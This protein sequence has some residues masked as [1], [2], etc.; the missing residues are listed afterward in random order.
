MTYSLQIS[1]YE[2]Y[3][4]LKKKQLGLNKFKENENRYVVEAALLGGI[5]SG[6]IMNSF[7]C[8]TFI[9]MTDKDA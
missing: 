1:I 3:F 4:D 7:E 9:K 6:C 2:T 8:L 5:F